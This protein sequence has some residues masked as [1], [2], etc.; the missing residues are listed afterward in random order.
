[1]LILLPWNKKISKEIF[2]LI[3]IKVNFI[4]MESKD[5]SVLPNT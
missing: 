2:Q 5:L 1:M 4:A 3:F